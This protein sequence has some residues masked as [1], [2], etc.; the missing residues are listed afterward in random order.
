MLPNRERTRGADPQLPDLRRCD[1]R[2]GQSPDAQ[3]VGVQA[4]V[5]LVLPHPLVGETLIPSG[6]ARCRR[7]PHSAITFAAQYRPRMASIATSGSAPAL[8]QLPG[9]RDGVVLDPHRLE[10]GAVDRHPEL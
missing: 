6:W 10:H 1:P 4:G 5:G 3:Q 9:Q 8:G 7:V 2:L